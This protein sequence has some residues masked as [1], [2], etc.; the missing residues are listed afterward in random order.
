MW[1]KKFWAAL[2]VALESGRVAGAALD[3]HHEE[4]PKDWR[5]ARHPQVLT[6]SHSTQ[7]SAAL[8]VSN[9]SETSPARTTTPT[10]CTSM[11]YPPTSTWVLPPSGT[12]PLTSHAAGLLTGEATSPSDVANR[13]LPSP[14]WLGLRRRE[15]SPRFVKVPTPPTSTTTVAARPRSSSSR[16]TAGRVRVIRERGEHLGHVVGVGGGEADDEGGGGGGEG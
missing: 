8:S 14:A 10:H 7:H 13:M 6:P 5:L 3:V 16:R 11:A 15:G 1:T 2:L 9:S 4:P 12:A